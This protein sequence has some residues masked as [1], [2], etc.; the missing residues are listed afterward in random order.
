MTAPTTTTAATTPM[1]I[2]VDEPEALSPLAA[3]MP[4]TDPGGLLGGPVGGVD[5]VAAEVGGE[6]VEGES[7][8][9][10]PSRCAHA[11]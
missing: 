2:P 3:V 9:G 4:W 7:V 6:L 11:S 1:T 8:V 10:G 5:G